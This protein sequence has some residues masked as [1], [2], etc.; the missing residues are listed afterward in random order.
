MGVRQFLTVMTPV[1][2]RNPNVFLQAVYATC[3]I[4]ETGGRTVLVPKKKVLGPLLH[5]PLLLGHAGCHVNLKHVCMLVICCTGQASPKP[6]A[7]CIEQQS[8][9]HA[10]AAIQAELSHDAAV[11]GLPC[12]NAICTQGATTEGGAAQEPSR[13]GGAPAA[14]GHEAPAT[15]AQGPSSRASG[16]TPGLQRRTSGAGGVP[17][18]PKT[19]ATKVCQAPHMVLHMHLFAVQV[20]RHCKWARHF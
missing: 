3:S 1:I 20:P 19:P 5:H 6:Q 15:S 13:Q 11:L 8:I 2:A 7:L 12:A 9:A 14:P 18:T 10:A 4:E 17:K 16:A